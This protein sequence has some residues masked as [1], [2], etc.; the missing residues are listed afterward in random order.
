MNSSS[1]NT[2]LSLFTFHDVLDKSCYLGDS[3]LQLTLPLLKSVMPRQ[4]K[5]WQKVSKK[6]SLSFNQLLT[7]AKIFPNFFTMLVNHWYKTC[8]C[9]FCMSEIFP[10]IS[11]QHFTCTIAKEPH[12]ST[13]AWR[14][15]WMR[16]PGGL[17]SMGS[18]RVRHNWSDLAAAAAAYVKQITNRDLLY[19]TGNYTQYFIIIYKG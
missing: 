6:N 8:W 4:G 3:D 13:L 14:I 9:I 5:F 16:E 1:F 10:H 19:S 2:T 7:R 11:N 12:S 17:P 18:H 15:P